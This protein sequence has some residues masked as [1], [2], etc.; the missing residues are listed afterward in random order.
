MEQAS[1]PVARSK[2]YLLRHEALHAVLLGI[3]DSLIQNPQKYDYVPYLATV[4]ADEQ[5]IAVAIRTPARPL[6]LSQSQ[7][8]SAMNLIAQNLIEY[9][10]SY[11]QLLTGVNAP[12]AESHAFASSWASITS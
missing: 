4:E 3:C 1:L 7:N 9:L 12:V 11:Q 10:R 8:L 5:I 2:D 6:L